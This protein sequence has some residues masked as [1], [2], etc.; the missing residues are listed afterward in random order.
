MGLEAAIN[1]KIKILEVYG[2][3]SLVIYQVRCDW[4]T[5]HPNLLPYQDYILELFPAFDEVTFEHIPREANQL[6]DALATL[7]AMF[8][9]SYLNNAPNIRILHYKE[10]AHVFPVHCLTTKDVTDEKPWY[11]NIKRYLEKQEYP[12]GAKIYDKWTLR[13]L[14]SKFLLSGDI[15]YKINYDSVLLTCVD[16]YEAESII[17]EIH[18]GSFGTNA[19]G[20]SMD[21]KI[22]RAGYF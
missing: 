19:S 13:R 8:K 4:D 3:F 6:A 14:A 15:L 22:L 2:D 16:R 9:V 10:P 12:E 11:F 17:R 5:R 18:E 1:L 21:K 7:A 20:H